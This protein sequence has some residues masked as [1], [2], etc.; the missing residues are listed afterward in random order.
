MY[1][2]AILQT[3]QNPNTPPSPPTWGGPSSAQ[4]T[5]SALLYT[6]LSTSLFAAFL[7][8]LGKQWVN[9]Y[10]RHMGGSVAER[11]EDRQRKL[12][13]IERWPFRI[14]I[15]SLPV[16]L[17][18]SLF[19]F[20]VALSHSLWDVNRSVALV[21]VGFT[22]F[23]V[24]FYTCIVIFGSFSY[25]C[26]FQ[27]P[28]S[29]ILRSLGVNRLATKLLSRFF[30][31]PTRS[32]PN[33]DCVFW[34]LDFITDPEMTVAALRHLTDIRWHHN[35]SEKVPLIQVARI[36][37]KCFGAGRR[38]LSGSRDMAHA[39]GRALIQLYVHRVCFDRNSDH[40]HE[41]VIDAIGHLSSGKHD[42][43]LQPLSSVAESIWERDWSS[44]YR[45]EV[46]HFD[47]PWISELWMYHTWFRRSQ[48]KGVRLGGIITECNTL[49]TV[50]RLFESEESPPPS[51]VRNILHGMLVGV[52][53][54]AISLDD[55]ITLH[56]WALLLFHSNKH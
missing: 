20:A 45:W 25:E 34:A 18:L 19:L 38:I 54:S 11:C 21:V 42:H 7:A 13:G 44:D 26:P 49:V 33:A 36:Y 55:L 2:K 41:A 29:L 32:T 31:R 50:A 9:R 39:A 56:R 14:V 46:A 6:S 1:L 3:L 43:T 53:S 28:L 30:P 8:M 37:M 48:L 27:T 51:V 24:L 17:Q 15:E 52:N 12:N 40:A 16:L 35:P 23:G 10:T 22:A 5:V 47:L 4:I